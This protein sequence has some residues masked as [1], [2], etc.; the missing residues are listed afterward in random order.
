[1][2]WSSRQRNLLMR[3]SAFHWNIL[4]LF[5]FWHC[6]LPHLSQPTLPLF[7][8]FAR[9]GIQSMLSD[10]EC[11]SSVTAASQSEPVS[12]AGRSIDICKQI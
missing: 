9:V 5:G 12:F 7:R 2:K 1:M 8:H 11:F 10:M 3:A 6:H 4:F